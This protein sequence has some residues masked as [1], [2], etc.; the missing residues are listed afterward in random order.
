MEGS[1]LV[2]PPTLYKGEHLKSILNSAAV[3]GDKFSLNHLVML[4]GFDAEILTDVLAIAEDHNIIL[5]GEL[6]GNYLFYHKE[7][8]ETLLSQIDPQVKRSLHMRLAHRLDGNDPNTI[9]RLTH[10][11]DAAE[12]FQIALPFALMAGDLARERDDLPEAERFYR[13]ALKGTTNSTTPSL[14][15]RVHENLAEILRLLGQSAEALLQFKTAYSL[16]QN[17]QD[18]ARILLHIS[19]IHLQEERLNE[20]RESSEKAL[21]LLGKYIPG[22]PV[23]AMLSLT[24]SLLIHFLQQAGLR[25]SL[26]RTEEEILINRLY[27]RLC[28][29]HRT[30]GRIK[31]LWAY[32]QQLNHSERLKN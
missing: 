20:A 23:S 21:K 13:V 10:H 5:R 9:F 24:Q 2:Q 28:Y 14:K 25:L 32:Y 30:Q 12:E 22:G 8:R 15:R 6:P 26:P 19:E 27:Q 7:M 18:R 1:F 16:G 4:S 31:F 3:I 17:A 11:L 29:T